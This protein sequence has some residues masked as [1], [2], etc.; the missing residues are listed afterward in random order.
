MIFKTYRTLAACHCIVSSIKRIAVCVII[1]MYLREAVV[2]I[3]CVSL[4]SLILPN[5][6]NVCGTLKIEFSTSSLF[7]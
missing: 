2:E 7:Q 4:E 1:V 6:K 5:F 3:N